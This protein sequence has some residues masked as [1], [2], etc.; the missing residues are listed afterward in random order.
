MQGPRGESGPAAHE[1]FGAEYGGSDTITINVYSDSC[2]PPNHCRAISPSS[3][4]SM[5]A[6]RSMISIWQ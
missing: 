2:Q 3:Q 6:A 4:T 1:P 5:E